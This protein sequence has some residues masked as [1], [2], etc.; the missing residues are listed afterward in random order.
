MS[1]DI[2]LN[3]PDP[4]ST[5]NNDA[6]TF[7]LNED[8]SPNTGMTDFKG[9]LDEMKKKMEDAGATEVPKPSKPLKFPLHDQ[10]QYPCEV[11]FKI[12]LRDPPSVQ[13]LGN[14]IGDVVDGLVDI[15]KAAV[16]A[17]KE[18]YE[19]SGEN[20]IGAVAGYTDGF[21]NEATNKLDAA[22]GNETI[23]PEESLNAATDALNAVKAGGRPDIGKNISLYL[24]GAY[25]V[26]DALQYSTFEFGAV[27]AA[28]LAALQGGG[29]VMES[30]KAMFMDGAGSVM[31]AIT[32][33]AGASEYASLS[34]IRGMSMVKSLGGTGGE[35]ATEAVK[36]TMGVTINPNTR[37]MFKAVGLRSFQL[38]FKF[39]PLS[40]K[41]AK[42]TEEIIKRFREHAY[43]ES[44][45]VGGVSQ[46]Y[47][48]PHMFDI[49]MYA[50]GKPVGTKI[51]PCV[52]ESISTTYNPSGM[53]YYKGEDRSYPAEY[54]LSLS[55]REDVTLNAQDIRDG[56]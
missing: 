30:I 10:D 43:P 13:G 22:L 38:Q 11:K 56:F 21:V 44:I 2:K 53:T 47:K 34:A 17:A 29:T 45:D 9:K 55:F 8:E 5:A 27:G 37:A 3:I 46:G 42:Q 32:G 4:Y 14:A 50:Y 33:N 1:D 16:A 24:P 19:E 7:S 18:E 12:L 25:A 26:S 40:E 51:K 20:P 54:T 35:I 52:L 6:F 36:L 49:E 15:N 28:G 41:E 48:Y 39:I 31:D 23:T